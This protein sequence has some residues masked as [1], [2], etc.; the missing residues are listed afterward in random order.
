VR[1]VLRLASAE[2]DRNAS[3]SPALELQAAL[4]NR[5]SAREDRWPP[6]ATAGFI[7]A[8]CGSFWALVFTVVS[9]L[10]HL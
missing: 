6:A 2:S 7:L 3:P 5:L 10:L 8:T 4:E 1:K 9:R